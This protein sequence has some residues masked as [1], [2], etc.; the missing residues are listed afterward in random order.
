MLEQSKGAEAEAEEGTD[1]ELPTSQT[2]APMKRRRLGKKTHASETTMEYEV[3][4]VMQADAEEGEAACDKR[5]REL[6]ALGDM[7]TCYADRWKF[8]ELLDMTEARLRGLLISRTATDVT[9]SIGVVVELKRRGLPAAARAFNQ[10]LSLVWSKH[11]NVKDAAVEA[12]FSMHLEGRSGAEAVHSLLEMYQT[13]CESGGWT[14]TH[15][16]SVSELIQQAAQRERIKPA[17]AIREL[18]R[19]VQGPACPMAI[20][21]LTALGAADSS[22]LAKA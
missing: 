14:Y 5:N 21:T 2:E 11:A 6:K 13:G 10:I 3:E 12:F 1:P 16:S 7:E 20:R 19:V 4:K 8:I 17:D 9:E 18:V 15:L 22:S